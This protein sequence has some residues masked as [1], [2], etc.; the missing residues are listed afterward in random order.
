MIK[1]V[2]TNT[3]I[4]ERRGVSAKTNKPYHL[5]TQYGY[6]YTVDKNGVVA[7]FPEKF[8]ISLEEGQFPYARGEYTLQPSTLKVVADSYGHSSL[9]VDRPRL[10]SVAAPAAVT[11]RA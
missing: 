5:R 11:S 3:P 9:A 1:I 6:A 10:V 4:D 2:I 8:E 7:D